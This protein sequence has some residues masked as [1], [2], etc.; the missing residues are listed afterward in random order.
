M[1]EVRKTWFVPPLM[2]LGRSIE[3]VDAL[4]T[5]GRD[6]HDVATWPTTVVLSIALP[7]R[8]S[9]VWKVGR[10]KGRGSEF[11]DVLALL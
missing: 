3:F 2:F 4:Q 5:C 9:E 7:R 8:G 11:V 1:I 6:R 10:L